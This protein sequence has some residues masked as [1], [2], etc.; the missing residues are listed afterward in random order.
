MCT[1]VQHSIKYTDMR[2]LYFEI[3]YFIQLI[4]ATSNHSHLI[5][6]KFL[7][8]KYNKRLWLILEQSAEWNF[9]FVI[10]QF[11]KG[12]WSNY[13]R[14]HLEHF[15]KP[16][17][18]ANLIH[19]FYRGTKFKSCFKGKN[20]P[21]FTINRQGYILSPLLFL[22]I[23]NNVMTHTNIEASHGVEQLNF[24]NTQWFMKYTNTAEIRHVSVLRDIK[25]SIRTFHISIKVLCETIEFILTINN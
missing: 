10:C 6:T 15:T 12:F 11:R 18:S 1:T 20:R 24:M 21:T 2:W 4:N 7:Q 16:W 19:E 5:Y 22:I 25:C 23:L 8:T 9:D 3:G 13:Q 17:H 14:N